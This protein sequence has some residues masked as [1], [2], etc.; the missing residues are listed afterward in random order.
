MDDETYYRAFEDVKPYK[1]RHYSMFRVLFFQIF[2]I[3]FIAVGGNY[4]IWRWFYSLN[5]D[6]LWFSL[7]LVIAETLIFFGSILMIINYW[8][9]KSVEQTKPVRMLSEIE[10][11]SLTGR[12]DRPIKIDVYIASFNEDLVLVE[13]TIRDAKSLRYPYDDVEIRLYLCDD[14]R[15]DGRDPVKEN[16]RELADNYGIGYFVRESNRGFKAGN[17]NHAFWQTDGD[18][19]VILDADTRVFPDF[20]AKLTGYF[21]DRKMAWVQSPQWFYDINRGV[22]VG[23]W[24]RERRP[25]LVRVM[26]FMP[27]LFRKY[28]AG[29]NILGTDP[30]IFY[31]SILRSR[32]SA[33]A[34]FCC[35]AGSMQ[36][37]YTLER[38][39]VNQ[40]ERLL[41]LDT[42]LPAAGINIKNP[43]MKEAIGS[44]DQI[45]GPFVH[46]I[47][48]DIYT[49]ILLHA[50]KENWKSYQHPDV[51]CK[52]LSPQTLSAYIKQF[53]RYAEGTFKLCFSKENPLVKKGLTFWQRIGYLDT[54][55]SYFSPFWIVVF[56]VSPVIFYFSLIPP[57]KAFN[58]DFFLRFL[59]FNI[60]NLIIVTT[61]N[62]G[63]STKRSE[64]YYISSFWYKLKAF[65][66][67]ITKGSLQFNTTSKTLQKENLY[68][69]IRHVIPHLLIILLTV[70]GFIY[71]SVLIAK[72]LHPSYSAFVANTLWAVYNIYQMNPIIR[73]S[74]K[75]T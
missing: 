11:L 51:E 36:R 17:M 73:A 46:H 2:S 5:P 70:A 65:F 21:R 71:N 27:Y 38:L 32:N 72:N 75:R 6:A 54:I 26:P 23:N 45:I 31:D 68:N 64:Q 18:L 24:L 7:P 63:M 59:L 49:S 12:E 43:G 35:G 9:P 52:M 14:G 22:N 20:L 37:R 10:D 47:S 69:N 33:N 58:F 41:E 4:L 25:G 29:K 28:Q 15:R 16:F 30:R 42:T 19:I 62:W 1:P 60:F 50:D 57:I 48:E 8:S 3:L 56:L 61:A 44:D 55:Y 53:S 66:K 74:L 67:V 13:D 34:A 40:K 39:I